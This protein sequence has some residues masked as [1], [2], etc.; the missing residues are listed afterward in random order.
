MTTMAHEGLRISDRVSYRVSVEA[1]WF[2]AAGVATKASAQTLLVSRNGG[3]LRMAEKLV[4]GQDLTL[5]RRQDGDQWKVAHARVVA[6]IDQEPEGY[7]YAI[8]ILDPRV[9]F[10]DIDFPEMH[11]AEEALARLLM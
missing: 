7:L 9:D 5:R 4:A 1:S 10:W 6:E 8:H 11:K 2:T 3:V